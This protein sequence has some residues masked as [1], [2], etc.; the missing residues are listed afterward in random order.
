MRASLTGTLLFVVM[1]VL[2]CAL[3]FGWSIRTHWVQYLLTAI[4][5]FAVSEIVRRQQDE[6]GGR[7]KP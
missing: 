2:V 4:L 6:F 1:Y 5:Y 7:A 3:M